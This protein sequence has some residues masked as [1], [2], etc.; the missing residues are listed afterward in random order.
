MTHDDAI[1]TKIEDR[2]G[3]ITI[4][5]PSALNAID[6]AVAEG[7]L[8]ACK[9]LAAD[10][11]VRVIVI[12]GAGKAFSVGGDL[13]M[14]RQSPVEAAESLIGPMHAVV[15]LIADIAVPVIASVHGVA[16][17][18][19]FSL[20]MACDLAIAAE[21]TRFNL[22]YLNVGASCDVGAS[23]HLPRL[24]GL[25]Q[26]MAIA[27]LNETLNADEALRV[28]LVNRVVPAA[29]LI[30]ETKTL[31]RSLAAKS[32]MAVAHLKRLLRGSIARGLNEQLVAEQEAFKACALT[33]DFSEAI[34]AFFENRPPT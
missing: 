22:A 29:D 5:R 26:S 17:G 32:P 15:N 20:A 34:S 11:N 9:Y 2:V 1:L 13:N 27:L 31:A 12:A 3:Y 14:L 21:G 4:N 6:A 25:R 18:A 7:M 10:R 16:A 28:G 24:V 30:V 33:T 19:G 23:W 8:S